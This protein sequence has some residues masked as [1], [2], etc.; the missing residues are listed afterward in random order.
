MDDSQY[1]KTLDRMRTLCARREY[2]A[3]DIRAKLV[4][5]PDADAGSIARILETL[6]AE[7]YLDDRRYACAF[8][9]DKALLRGWGEM[10]IRYMLS[11]KGISGEDIAAALAEIDRD[12]VAEKLYRA[13]K[14][15]YESLKDDPACKLKLL[16]FALGRGY[17]YESAEKAVEMVMEK[18]R[19]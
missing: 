19:H 2:C 15:K 1:R 13:V 7:K 11:S 4:R 17:D 9:R 6:Y 3:A 10:K 12:R 14:G 16:R 8:C 18:S 5:L